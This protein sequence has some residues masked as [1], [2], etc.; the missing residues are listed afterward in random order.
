LL[1]NIIFDFGNVL[2]DLDLGRMGRELQSCLGDGYAAARQL[3]L[4][5]RLFERYETGHLGTADFI[6]GLCRAGHPA[7][8]PERAIAAWNAIFLSLPRERLDLLL[9]LRRRYG[10]YMLS[11]INELHEQWITAYLD[12]EY[13]IRDFETRY[14]DRVYYSHRIGLRKPDPASFRFVLDDAGLRPEECLFIDDLEENVQA[15]RRLGIVGM[16]HPP[17][18]DLAERL[19][20]LFTPEVPGTNNS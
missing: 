18:A 15:A 11:N 1:K 10:V 8:T 12:R 14:F 4:Q 6:G 20:P 9:R 13:G 16:V 5:E 2:F 19:K 17:G 7:L 3:A